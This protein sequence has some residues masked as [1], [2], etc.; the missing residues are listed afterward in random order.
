MS[1]EP[2]TRAQSYLDALA[3]LRTLPTTAQNAIRQKAG[4]QLM[5]RLETANAMDWLT[6]AEFVTFNRAVFQT[7][8]HDAFTTFWREA[9]ARNRTSPIIRG[10]LKFLVATVGV[11]PAS[12]LKSLPNAMSLTSENCGKLSIR[13]TGKANCTELLM[14][15]MPSVLLS[16]PAYLEAMRG[17]LYSI[18]DMVKI[19]GDVDLKVN[20]QGKSVIYRFTW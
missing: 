7:L 13:E 20:P 17:G 8:N 1:S 18:F 14:E 11:S 19:R 5:R 12:L 10:V 6:P 16:E 4:E 3:V 15:E 9:A 2:R